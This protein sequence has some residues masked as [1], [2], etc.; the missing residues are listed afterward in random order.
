MV[1]I[2]LAEQVTELVAAVAQAPWEAMEGARLVAM[3]VTAQR[4]LF[5][6]LALLTQAVAAVVVAEQLAGL[7]ALVAVETVARHQ[8][9]GTM[10]ALIL[11]AVVVA[12]G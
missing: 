2:I 12:E 9:L 4:R 10:V 7:A 5:L 11:A 6:A 8:L 1:E 3:E